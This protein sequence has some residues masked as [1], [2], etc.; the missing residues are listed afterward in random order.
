MDDKTFNKLT[1]HVFNTILK[2][3]LRVS[4]VTATTGERLEGVIL[5]VFDTAIILRRAKHITYLTYS[6]M[7]DVVVYDD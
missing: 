3:G 5:D 7:S 2:S 4:I 1:S 6:E